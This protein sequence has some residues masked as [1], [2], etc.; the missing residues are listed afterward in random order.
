MVHDEVD[1]YVLLVENRQMLEGKCG[2]LFQVDLRVES[3]EYG[4]QR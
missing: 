4:I 2:K 1:F 3:G